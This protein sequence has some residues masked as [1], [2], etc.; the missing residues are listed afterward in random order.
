MKDL[1][2]RAAPAALG[3]V[4]VSIDACRSP[5]QRA[6]SQVPQS[7]VEGESTLDASF[8]LRAPHAPTV[9]PASFDDALASAVRGPVV[10]DDASAKEAGGPSNPRG[11]WDGGR[12]VASSVEPARQTSVG[13]PCETDEDC[14]PDGI[15]AFPGAAR[16]AARG[17]CF[18]RPTGPENAMAVPACA[19][20]GT[21]VD[22]GSFGLPRG[23][24]RKPLLHEG[25]CNTGDPAP[26]AR[27]AR[28]LSPCEASCNGDL[29][30]LM[31][32]PKDR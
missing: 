16:C 2:L 8:A 24:H 17:T 27:P 28:K 23:F 11:Q 19:C 31:Q 20:N 26:P 5:S 32:C 25:V 10:A 14:I 12:S 29:M 7:S 4:F 18:R 22:L 30:C 1:I 3:L 13:H 21:Y 15:C 6:S 9:N